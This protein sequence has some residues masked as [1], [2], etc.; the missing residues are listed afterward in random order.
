M[1]K[2]THR[3][4]LMNSLMKLVGFN[5]LIS[6]YYRF[7]YKSE[8]F[9]T[10]TV[11]FSINIKTLYK[12][13]FFIIL[14]PTYHTNIIKVLQK[15]VIT[16]VLSFHNLTSR[17]SSQWDTCQTLLP[18][19]YIINSTMKNINVAAKELNPSQR[20]KLW[21][22]LPSQRILR[23]KERRGFGLDWVKVD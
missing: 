21:C 5:W 13:P 19:L 14:N 10:P 4:Y 23:I 12:Y 18:P 9:K 3:K 6:F 8:H 17:R 1:K 22:Y 7:H 2:C 16:G 11:F 15:F 20:V